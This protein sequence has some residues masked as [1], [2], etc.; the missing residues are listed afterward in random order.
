MIGA[1][2]GAAGGTGGAFP[3]F[4]RWFEHYLLGAKNGVED[5]PPVELYVGHGS[6]EALVG[7]QW[8]G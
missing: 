7:G 1:H 8:T 3:R 6:H 4:Q 2:D 5:K